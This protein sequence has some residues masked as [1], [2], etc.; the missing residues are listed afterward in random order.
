MK[1]IVLIGAGKRV[2]E[3]IIPSIL[4]NK[5]FN[6]KQI[7]SRDSGKIFKLNSSFK[8]LTFQTSSL[9]ELDLSFIDYIYIGIKPNAIINVVEH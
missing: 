5:V 6:I 7:I 8:E 4:I 1:N 2:K 9:D 3:T